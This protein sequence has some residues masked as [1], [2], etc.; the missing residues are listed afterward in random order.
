MNI[1]LIYLALN[2]GL[3]NLVDEPIDLKDTQIYIVISGASCHECLLSVNDW[4]SDS[5]IETTAIIWYNEGII[6]KREQ[7]NYYSEF[8]SPDEWVFSNDLEKLDFVF[9][10]KYSPNV[11]VLKN[12][13]IYYFSYS[14]LFNNELK[15]EEFK[16]LI[17]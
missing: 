13:E 14:N 15:I 11:F 2:I 16:Q 5:K 1:L 6:K 4:V 12:G 17:E 7:I 10:L 9:N 3:L 8:I